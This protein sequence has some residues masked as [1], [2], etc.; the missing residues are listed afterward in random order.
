VRRVEADG[1]TTDV[2]PIQASE[3]DCSSGGGWFTVRDQQ[4]ITV[5]LCPAQCNEHLGPPVTAFQLV[6][7]WQIIE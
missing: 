5:T 1:G 3:Q 4:G 7:W 2:L 6:R